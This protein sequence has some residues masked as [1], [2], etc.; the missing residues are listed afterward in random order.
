MRA[1]QYSGTWDEWQFTCPTCKEFI[2][3]STYEILN[4]FV[5]KHKQTDGCRFDVDDKAI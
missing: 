5:D 2:V 4:V 1:I 3:G